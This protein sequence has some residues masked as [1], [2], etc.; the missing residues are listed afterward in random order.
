MSRQSPLQVLV[1]LHQKPQTAALEILLADI[2]TPTVHLQTLLADIETPT[3]HIQTLL[4]DIETPT[5]HIQPLL[6]DIETPAVQIQITLIPKALP[7]VIIEMP[8]RT[9]I[10]SVPTD[11]VPVGTQTNETAIRNLRLRDTEP[12]E[13]VFSRLMPAPRAIKQSSK[14]PKLVH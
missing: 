6:A 5:V 14:V 11:K 4:A 2:E 3:V 12:K 13:S 8:L 7:R 10:R 1:M 9:V